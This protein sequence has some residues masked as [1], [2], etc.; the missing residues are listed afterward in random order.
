[1]HQARKLQGA[2]HSRISGYTSERGHRKD[3]QATTSRRVRSTSELVVKFKASYGF[4]FVPASDLSA[5]RVIGGKSIDGRKEFEKL[6][7]A[8]MPG[9]TV[10]V[11][12]TGPPGTVKP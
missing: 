1:M 11:T 5:P 10:V 6:V 3:I 12:K 4:A 8:L 9:D 7:K 2:A